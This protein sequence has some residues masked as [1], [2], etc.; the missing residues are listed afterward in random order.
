MRTF[1]VLVEQY[2]RWGGGNLDV[3]LVKAKDL[4]DLALKLEPEL[5]APSEEEEE[6]NEPWAEL[7]EA[8]G[9]GMNYYLVKELVGDKLVPIPADP[10]CGP[11]QGRPDATKP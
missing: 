9:D 10:E 7:M 6:P 8:N 1:I 3:R 2:E 11:S 4:N 5:I